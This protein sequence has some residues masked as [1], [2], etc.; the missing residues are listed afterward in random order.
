MILSF[1]ALRV[2]KADLKACR[3]SKAGK[4]FINQYKKAF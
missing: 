2:S 4:N 1:L 3:N